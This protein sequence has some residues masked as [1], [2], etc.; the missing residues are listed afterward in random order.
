MGLSKLFL[1]QWLLMMPIDTKVVKNDG[2]EL[3]HD[4]C[5]THTSL[6]RFAGYPFVTSVVGITELKC[7]R[8]SD[9]GV[10]NVDLRDFIGDLVGFYVNF[11]EVML[12]IWEIL[13]RWNI[14]L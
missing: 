6:G 9:L 7:G 1:P 13:P 5:G 3:G 4:K 2:I 14:G 8:R 12:V 10:S 11:L